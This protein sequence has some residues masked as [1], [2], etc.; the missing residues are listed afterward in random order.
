MAERR[1]LLLLLLLV[2]LALALSGCGEPAVDLDVPERAEDQHVLDEVGLL[3]D[4][5]EQRLREVSAAS[6][7]DVVALV[8]EDERTSLGQADRGG[9]LLLDAWDADIVLV[10]VARPGDFASAQADRSRFFGVFA[11]DRFTVSRSLRERIIF[12]RVQLLAAENE[13]G[14]AFAAA[15]E[16]LATELPAAG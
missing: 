1:P 11:T 7:F 4:A 15:I 3:D 16:E 8:F 13:W 14:P 12:E 6:G 9:K 5:I 10:A 2:A